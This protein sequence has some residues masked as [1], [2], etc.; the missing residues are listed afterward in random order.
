MKKMLL[1]LP[2]AGMLLIGCSDDDD[3]VTTTQFEAELQ[4]FA[5]YMGWSQVDYTVSDVPGLSGAHMEGDGNFTR[6]IYASSNAVPVSGVYPDGSILV[7]ETYTWNEETGD[8]EYAE[9]GGLLGM[10]KRGGDFNPGGGGWEWFML[11]SD[12][13][14]IA[15]RGGEEMMD[16]ACNS[17]HGASETYGGM[18]H[19]FQHPSEVM[20]D[21]DSFTGY[22]NWI[23]VDH[24]ISDIPGLAG[25]HAGTDD[26]FTR[27]VYA[28]QRV[29]PLNG[30]FPIGTKLVKE[31]FSWNAETGAREFAEM[32]GLLG[33]V[34]RGGSFNPDHGGWEWFMLAPNLSAIA[35]Q[36]ADLMDGACNSCHSAETTYGGMDY[37]FPH[38]S[39]VVADAASF[40]GYSDWNLLEETDEDH[41]F[42]NPAHQSGNEFAT[43]RVYRRQ[44]LA[45]PA[46]G[47]Y[48]V[49]TLMV[50]EVQVEGEVVEITAMAK[51]GGGFDSDNGDW[52]YFMLSPDDGSVADRGAIGMC[53]GCHLNASGS[54]GMDHVFSHSGDP[55]NN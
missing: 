21:L 32:G 22:Q 49:G 50:K 37:V 39:E 5:N 28:N 19:V 26:A 10:V 52:E 40:T 43:R 36:G 6:L 13:S 35:A 29:N 51:R 12:L 16:G 55:F 48:P 31:T 17:C 34:K 41:P 47:G 44:L 33:M 11:E 20:A 4:D 30:Q 25:A 15:A 7:K 46:H 1:M 8:K 45:N 23:Q 2:M 24:T 27:V 54:H 3:S 18:D 9:M 38:P 53:I 42:L 14:G